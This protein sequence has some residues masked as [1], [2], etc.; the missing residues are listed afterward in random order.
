MIACW[1]D[2]STLIPDLLCKLP[3]ARTVLDQYGLRGCGGQRTI[4]QACRRMDV[5]CRQF[6]KALNEKCTHSQ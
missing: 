5:D 3:Q 4:E 2:N 6:L 1:P